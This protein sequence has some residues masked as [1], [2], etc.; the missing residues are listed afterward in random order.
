MDRNNSVQTILIVDDDSEW[1]NFLCEV[2]GK[3]YAVM[4]ATSGEDGI[5]IAERVRPALIMLDVVMPGGKDGFTTFV[6]LRKSPRTQ[7][8]PVIFVSGVNLIENTLFGV[9]TLKQF[10]GLAPAAFL[11]KPIKQAEVLLAVRKVLEPDRG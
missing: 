8:I 7:D 4:I 9:D 3:H 5:A 2:L 10:L 6:E 11:E 1:R